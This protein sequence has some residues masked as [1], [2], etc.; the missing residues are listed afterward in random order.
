MRISGDLDVN[1]TGGESSSFLTRRLRD[2][3]CDAFYEIC[4]RRNNELCKNKETGEK[5]VQETIF[6]NE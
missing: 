4:A 2:F 6:R 3:V 1:A 5:N